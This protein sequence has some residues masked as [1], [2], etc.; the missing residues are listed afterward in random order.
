MNKNELA[1]EIVDAFMEHF[2]P[3]AETQSKAELIETVK[4]I[5]LDDGWGSEAKSLMEDQKFLENIVEQIWKKAGR[6][7]VSSSAKTIQDFEIQDKGFDHPDYFRG[8]GVAYTKWDDVYVGVGDSPWEAGQDALDALEQAG[9]DVP[10]DLKKE[11]NKLSKK[12]D[13]AAEENP[14]FLHYIAVYIK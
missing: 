8:A 2:N 14:D 11:A 3:E 7:K 12:K 10:H 13:P 9:Y 1:E 5:G 6:S 4:N